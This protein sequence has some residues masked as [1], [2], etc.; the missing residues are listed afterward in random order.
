MKKNM[1]YFC[2]FAVISIP[3]VTWSDILDKSIITWLDWTMLGV[4]A[5]IYILCVAVVILQL[6]GAIISL[7]K[8]PPKE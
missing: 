7:R 2:W 5:S 3:L 1:V 6:V 8:N 4:V